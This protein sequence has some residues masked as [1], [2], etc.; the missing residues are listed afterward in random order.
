M[1]ATGIRTSASVEY[2]VWKCLKC[3]EEELAF[4]G[5]GSEAKNALENDQ[6]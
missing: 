4:R 1:K 2:V 5:L 3:T 6:I